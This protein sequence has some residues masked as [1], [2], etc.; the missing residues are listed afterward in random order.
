[1]LGSL[2]S[3]AFALA[4]LLPVYLWDVQRGEWWAKLAA[5]LNRAYDRMPHAEC[6]TRRRGLMAGS[7]EELF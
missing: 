5:E 6:V 2:L 3:A 1:M 4:A 7:P